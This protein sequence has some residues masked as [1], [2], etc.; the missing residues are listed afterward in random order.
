MSIFRLNKQM[1]K[2]KYTM[3]TFC[4]LSFCVDKINKTRYKARVYDK[5][6]IV[7][8]DSIRRTQW[9]AMRD[10]RDKYKTVTKDNVVKNDNGN[11]SDKEVV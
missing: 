7:W 4:G 6:E 10:L 1:V 9:E 11:N 8:S 2:G 5:G 3:T